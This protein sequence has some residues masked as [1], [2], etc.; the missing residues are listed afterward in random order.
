VTL[1]LFI[2]VNRWSRSPNLGVDEAE[3]AVLAV[4][5]SEWDELRTAEWLRGFLEPPDS[6]V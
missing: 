4:A 6:Q 3:Q 5:S 2:A 1:R